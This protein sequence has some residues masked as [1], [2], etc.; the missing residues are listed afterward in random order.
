MQILKTNK[1]E[2]LTRT[3]QCRCM[4]RVMVGNI[5]LR[6]LRDDLRRITLSTALLTLTI[7]CWSVARAQDISFFT[8]TSFPQSGVGYDVVSGD[9][10][11]DGKPDLATVS[12]SLVSIFLGRGDGTFNAA[13]NFLAGGIGLARTLAVGDFNQDGKL[14]LAVGNYGSVTILIGVGDGTFSSPT[15]F[16]TPVGFAKVAVRDVNGDGELDL[17]VKNDNSNPPCPNGVMCVFGSHP[18]TVSVL[19]GSG[20]GLFGPAQIVASFEVYNASI[21]FV[22]GDF[23]GDGKL[24]LAVAWD[25]L[26]VFLGFGDGTFGP[27]TNFSLAGAGIS[28][29]FSLGIGDFNGDGKSDLVAGGLFGRDAIVLLGLGDGTFSPA[30]VVDTAGGG[31]DLK[32]G[33]FNGD[34]KLDL[35]AI[36]QFRNDMSIVLGVGDGTFGNSKLFAV[37]ADPTSLVSADFNGDGYLDLAVSNSSVL[38]G[39]GDGTFNA[40]RN[41][42]VSSSTSTTLA[43]GDLNGDGILDLVVGDSFRN[44]YSAPLH[45]LLGLSDGTFGPAMDLAAFT[46]V[47]PTFYSIAIADFNADGKLDV[48]A[49]DVGIA[50]GNVTLL[51]GL[52]DGTFGAS[53][54]YPVGTR[55]MSMALG[56]F[57]GDGKLDVVTANAGSNNVSIVLGSGDG[58][59]ALAMNFPVGGGPVSVVVGD[60]NGDGKLDLAVANGSTNNVSILLGLG[61]GNFGPATNFTVQGKPSS[62]ATGDF[63]GDGKLDLIVGKEFP[64]VL[65]VLLGNGDGTF[66]VNEYVVAIDPVRVVAGDFNADGRMDVAFADKVRDEVEIILGFG[67]GTFIQGYD[68]VVGDAPISLTM[69]DFNRDGKLDLVVVDDQDNRAWIMLNTT[70]AP[71][72]D[73]FPPF[74][75]IVSHANN[76]TVNTSQITLAGTARDTAFGDSGIFSVTVNGIAANNGTASGGGVA[77]WSSLMPLNVGVNVLTVVAKDNSSNQN[78]ATTQVNVNYQPPP[79]VSINDIHVTEGNSGTTNAGFNVTLSA[80]SSQLVTVNYSTANGSAIA[81]ADYVAKSGSVTF[82]PGETS[83][84]ITISVI[85]DTIP[86]PNKAFFV[87]LTSAVNATIADGQGLGTI[88]DDDPISQPTVDFDGDGRSDIGIYRNGTWSI[89]RSIDGGVTNIGW[90]GP[91]WVPVPADYDGDGKIDIAVYNASGLWSI[92]RSSDGGNTL[93]G[94]SGAAGDIPVPADYDGD[95]KADLAVYNPTTAGWSIIRSSDGGLT[96]KAWGGPSYMPVVS[97]FDGDGEAD[98]AVY[99]ANGL[100]SIVRSSDGGNTLIGWSGAANDV[101][102]PADYDGD[103]KADLAVYNTATAGWSIIRSSDGGLTYKVWGGP[104]WEPVVADYDGDGKADIAVYNA[105]NGLWSIVRS[106]DGG[107]TLLGLGGAPQ[108]IPLN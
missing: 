19:L 89:I 12:D 71:V 10:N 56:D 105:S 63:N 54:S 59:F 76:Q 72:P 79:A 83:K 27:A 21:A 16:T 35:V 43:A 102:V 8:A 104:A 81:G 34:G 11:G 73:L 37:G 6:K 57:N 1:M 94:W 44:P 22:L 62:I 103:G 91:T 58:T 87:N 2:V 86:E 4:R 74:L 32:I 45:V 100:W 13:G 95:G 93:V 107:N 78:A 97:D 84:P 52:G 33:D 30:T 41:F 61:N 46:G 20:G 80:S 101:P 65:S 15:D 60:F 5:Q 75:S 68:A 25:Q 31:R 7:F 36:N 9:F 99:N 50:N 48:A 49:V 51:P 38:L 64:N 96:Y 39:H 82:N 24:D 70:P 88:I 3:A 55:P 18:Q 53:S 85:G 69:G 98:I 42:I 47:I 26:S 67:D 92:V 17:V 66:T 29:W 77:N 106:S 28:S 108:D 40:P 14:D 23:N 90:G